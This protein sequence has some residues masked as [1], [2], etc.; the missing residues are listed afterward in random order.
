MQDLKKRQLK[1]LLKLFV[2][3]VIAL[4]SFVY[5][6]YES[7]EANREV[8]SSTHSVQD[9]NFRYIGT[10]NVD[11]ITD[12]DTIHV[13]DSSGKDLKVRFLVVNT[14]EIH[15]ADKRKRCFAEMGKNYTKESLLS[16]DVELWGDTTQPELDKYGRTL[17]YIKVVNS[18]T[19]DF[20]NDSL[21]K[22]GLAKVYKASPPGSLYNKYLELQ[23]Q[24]MKDGV[25][26]WNSSLCN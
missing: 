10:F 17:A 23:N 9:S 22:N 5:T 26:M 21:M 2:V 1:R 3:L 14:L 12:G 13:K 19:S 24:A 6:Q 18:T 20:Y 8:S 4:R 25:G 16:K 11:Y 15:D 7:F